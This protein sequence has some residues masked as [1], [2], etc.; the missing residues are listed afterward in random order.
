MYNLDISE[1]VELYFISVLFSKTSQ[2]TARLPLLTGLLTGL[3]FIAIADT[4]V[5]VYTLFIHLGTHA[6][7]NYVK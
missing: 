5:G 7:M 1:K 3:R 6:I 4:F 2:S